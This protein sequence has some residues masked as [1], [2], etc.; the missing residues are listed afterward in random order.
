MADKIVSQKFRLDPADHLL[1]L[2]NDEPTNVD[3]GRPWE[4]L[5]AISQF[6]HEDKF[7]AILR[8]G[9]MPFVRT[10]EGPDEGSSVDTDEL[11]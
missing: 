3:I 4:G 11:V 7:H 5:N 2:L 6:P 9:S 1:E 8:I 10:A